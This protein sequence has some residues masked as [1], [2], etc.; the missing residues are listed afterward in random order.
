MFASKPLTGD[1]YL[2]GG[3]ID[4]SDANA[5]TRGLDVGLTF[6][7]WFT[8]T[9]GSGAQQDDGYYRFMALALSKAG[10][11]LTDAVVPLGSALDGK[12]GEAHYFVLPEHNHLQMLNGNGG[13]ELHELMV[14]CLIPRILAHRDKRLKSFDVSLPE[15]PVVLLFPTDQSK[16][17]AKAQVVG[18]DD[19]QQ[20]VVVDDGKLQSLQLPAG[21]YDWPQWWGG[22]QL[23][24]SWYHDGVSD[25]VVVRDNQQIVNITNNGESDFPAIQADGMLATFLS[26][27]NLIVRSVGGMAQV[28][29]QGPVKLVAPP[30]FLGDKIYFLHQQAD[31]RFE[32]RWVQAYKKAVPLA[33]TKLVAD[34][35]VSWTKIGSG[36]LA[37]Q[38][39][40]N[41]LK[42]IPVVSGFSA[43]LD[44]DV[45]LG[46]KA[47]H[48]IQ[49]LPKVS[50]IAVA[51]DGTIYVGWGIQLHQ[52]DMTCLPTE[53]MNR[54][55][56]ARRRLAGESPTEM[57]QVGVDQLLP[58][59]AEGIYRVDAK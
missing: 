30:I 21:E 44:V 50:E 40:A 29:V 55:E 20:V 53:T 1:W 59:V 15:M 5:I 47:L 6:D 39:T 38:E 54:L 45:A 51:G 19:Q 48:S 3:T 46:V 49:G 4:V 27:G 8:S 12:Q 16:L 37:F 7:R 32:L 24:A 9:T 11:P 56:E 35:V 25:I 41:G 13:T 34:N 52:L 18:L 42:P 28:V 17:I 14:R 58:L 33:S 22:N 2:A 57:K 43:V 23:I 10:Y 31:G 26:E 36:L